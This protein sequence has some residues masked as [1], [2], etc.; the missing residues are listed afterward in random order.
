[1]QNPTDILIAVDKEKL[2]TEWSN[3]IKSLNLIFVTVFITGFFSNSK[4]TVF[5]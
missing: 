4:F 3:L 2:E 1:M 5:Q